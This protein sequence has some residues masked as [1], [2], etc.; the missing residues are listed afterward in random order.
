MILSCAFCA[1]CGF[2]PLTVEEE[3]RPP[4]GRRD[5]RRVR[6]RRDHQDHHGRPHRD[7]RYSKHPEVRL[8]RE[9]R[10]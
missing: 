3:D 5:H 8:G 4:A 9:Y 2:F 7:L 10:L 6:Q 1:S